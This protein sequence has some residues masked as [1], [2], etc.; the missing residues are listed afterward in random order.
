MAVLGRRAKQTK[1]AGGDEKAAVQSYFDTKGGL[2]AFLTCTLL[3]PPVNFNT[4]L[5]LGL[6]QAR[7]KFM[8]AGQLFLPDHTSWLD[9]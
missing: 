2:V 5:E 6:L 4:T 7:S 1:L 3:A 9:L 8:A